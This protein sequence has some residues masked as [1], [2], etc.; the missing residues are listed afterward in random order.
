VRRCAIATPTVGRLLEE[1]E[2]HAPSLFS[3]WFE[4][5]IAL[6]AAT[7]LYSHHDSD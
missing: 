5:L 3:A 1:D 2:A 4:A 6:F 7:R